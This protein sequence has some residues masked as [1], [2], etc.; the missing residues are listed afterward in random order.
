MSSKRPL[1]NLVD[2]FCDW[3]DKDPHSKNRGFYNTSITES[4]LGSLEESNFKEFFIDFVKQGGKVQTGGHRTIN[5]F[6]STIEGT[7]QEFRNFTLQPFKTNFNLEEWLQQ[8]DNFLGFGMG[9]AT[10]Y[11]NRTNPE[12]YPILNNK[13]INALN[14]LGYRISTTKN[15]TNYGKVRAYQRDLIN[16]YPRLEDY[17]KADALTHFIVSVPEGKVLISTY[18]QNFSLQDAMEQAEIDLKVQEN[19]A[20][21]VVY[22]KIKSCENDKSDKVTIQGKTYKR[23]SYLFSLIKKYR[24]FTCQFCSIQLPIGK[25]KFYIE[26]CHIKP[27]S[28]GGKDKLNNILVL[29]PNCHKIFDYSDRKNEKLKDDQYTVTI[30]DET[31]TASL[32]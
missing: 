21:N 2:A 6:I 16:K 11:L 3:Y 28:V 12:A 18:Q 8:L 31:Y 26:A 25:G 13:T 24:N 20:P 10:I 23:N 1:E 9:I 29:C 15:F 30:N 22:D 17:Y 19:E 4:N 7:Y 27:K 32:S 5:N 14:K